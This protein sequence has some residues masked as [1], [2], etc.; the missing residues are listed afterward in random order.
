LTSAA[1]IG[2]QWGADLT[3]VETVGED[4]IVVLDVSRS[5]DTQ[6]VSPSRLTRSKRELTELLDSLAGERIGLVVFTGRSYLQ[7]PLTEDRGAIQLFLD[8]LTTEMFP[9]QGSTLEGLPELIDEI[10]QTETK[11]ALREKNL[12]LVSDG[13]LHDDLPSDFISA[14]KSRSIKVFAVEVG[15]ENGGPV[16]GDNGSYV[17]DAEGHIVISKA[18]GTKLQEMA[19]ATLGG[20]HVLGPQPGD[21]ARFYQQA[22]STI[23]RQENARSRQIQQPKQRFQWFLGLALLFC[24]GELMLSPMIRRR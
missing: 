9:N 22:K 13:E 4:L 16:I 24:L 11:A 2:P 18:S 17:K 15:T 20:F 1:I 6:D 5:M 19:E 10:Y 8:G 7:C 23:R 21:M 14:L 12:L 3:E